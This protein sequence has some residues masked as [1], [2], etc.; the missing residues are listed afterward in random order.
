MCIILRY[1]IECRVSGGGRSG[2]M[3]FVKK[4]NALLWRY[5]RD[6]YF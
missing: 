4:E 5:G 2:L 6:N 1:M 3:A